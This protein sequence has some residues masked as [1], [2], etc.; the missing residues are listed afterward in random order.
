MAT[1]YLTAAP[2]Q[3]ASGVSDAPQSEAHASRLSPALVKGV[4]IHVECPSWCTVDHVASPEN[5]VEDIWHA[6]DYANLKVPQ[7]NSRD[8]MFAFARLG[9]DPE[10]GITVIHVDDHS[11]GFDMSPK[12]AAT[13]TANLRAFADEIDAMAKTA[14]GGGV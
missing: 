1:S 9:F 13:F 8:D 10:T 12:Q 3:P 5:F 6:G 11:E 2:E 14:K 4:R 7:V